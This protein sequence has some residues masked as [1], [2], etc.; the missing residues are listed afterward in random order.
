VRGYW[1]N[2]FFWIFP[3]PF[4]LLKITWD[5]GFG[6]WVLRS[7]GAFGVWALGFGVS[8]GAAEGARW[9]FVNRVPLIYSGS[10]I[11]AEVA[12]LVEQRFRKP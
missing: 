2:G 11:R 12:Q 3:V 6:I 10:P 9:P 4:F 8:S 5:L 1:S 7:S